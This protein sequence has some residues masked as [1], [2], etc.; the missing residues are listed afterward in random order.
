MNTAQPW[1]T[2]RNVQSSRLRSCRQADA[3][4]PS[5][6][7]AA[8]SAT[9]QRR[10]GRIRGNANG[11]SQRAVKS[12]QPPIGRAGKPEMA[13]RHPMAQIHAAFQQPEA[14]V[15][16]PAAEPSQRRT[17]RAEQQHAESTHQAQRHQRPEQHIEHQRHQRQNVESGQH[18]RQRQQPKH[19]AGLRKADHA[20]ASAFAWPMPASLRFCHNQPFNRSFVAVLLPHRP[21][22]AAAWQTRSVRRRTGTTIARRRGTGGR[23]SAPA[24][25]TRRRPAN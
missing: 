16:Q 9:H 21:N 7:H 12:P 11:Q 3:A 15:A 18:Q 4:K 23:D 10:G 17:D 1:P 14:R 6:I 24:R 19:Q 25:P 20:T 8:S 5:A 13:A 22:A 2:L